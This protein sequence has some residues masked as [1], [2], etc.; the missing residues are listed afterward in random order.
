MISIFFYL[1]TPSF[2]EV[3]C[4]FAPVRSNDLSIDVKKFHVDSINKKNVRFELQEFDEIKVLKIA[5]VSKY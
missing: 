1:T 3:R 2:D 4:Y 5:R